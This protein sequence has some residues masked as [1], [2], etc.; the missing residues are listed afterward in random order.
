MAMMEKFT[1]QSSGLTSDAHVKYIEG[2]PTLT[3]IPRGSTI[4]IVSLPN[5]REVITNTASKSFTPSELDPGKYAYTIQKYPLYNNPGRAWSVRG[6][7]LVDVNEQEYQNL[8]FIKPRF[9][10]GVSTTKGYRWDCGIARCSEQFTSVI[11]AV[12][13][14]GEHL[15]IDFLHTNPDEVEDAMVRAVQKEQLEPKEPPPPTLRSAL[16]VTSLEEHE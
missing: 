9:A 13:H 16:G 8:L 10:K 12:Q 1:G 5:R 14:E 6:E 11:A 2:K 3:G 15:G 4:C 7:F